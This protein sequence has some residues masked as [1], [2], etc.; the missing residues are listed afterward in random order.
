MIVDNHHNQLSEAYR[1]LEEGGIAG[2][3]VWGRREKSSFFTFTS[4]FAIK[5]GIELP[6]TGRSN[7]H[8]SDKDLLI[9]DLKAAGFSEVK[10]FYTTA[11]PNL[12]GVDD[13]FHFLVNTPSR[14]IHYE[15]LT[16]ERRQEIKEE[17][18]QQFEEKF[19]EESMEMTTWENLVV[20]AKK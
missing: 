2:F 8:L 16:E 9:S 3:T 1:V 19:G 10:A 15:A 18:Y 7:F 6:S 20:I 14:K 12:G 13:Y 17:F 11:N 5:A 4:D